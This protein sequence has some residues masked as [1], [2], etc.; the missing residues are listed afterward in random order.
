MKTKTLL[1]VTNAVNKIKK[2]MEMIT[3]Y[4][5]KKGFYVRFDENNELTAKLAKKYEGV[6]RINTLKFNYNTVNYCS[7]LNSIITNEKENLKRDFKHSFIFL[8]DNQVKVLSDS[9]LWHISYLTWDKITYSEFN[10]IN[11][12]NIVKTWMNGKYII[13]LEED[14]YIYLKGLIS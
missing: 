5:S 7:A 12:D 4:A 14:Q 3:A 1:S 2:D 13:Q 6:Y 9:Y 8:A 11:R 10:D